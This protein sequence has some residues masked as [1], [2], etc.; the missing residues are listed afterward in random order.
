[1]LSDAALDRVYALKEMRIYVCNL[2]LT[3]IFTVDIDLAAFAQI[4]G[5]AYRPR[6]F[7]AVRFRV[8]Q[9]KCTM[10]VFKSGK[11]VCIGCTKVTHAEAAINQCFRHICKID[12]TAK[13]SKIQVQNIVSHTNLGK[14]VDLLKMSKEHSMKTNY[15][16]ELFPGLRM[17]LR[18]QNARAC[19]FFQG[20]V[21]VTG[22]KDFETLFRVW[23]IV[24]E[25]I[26]P[27][28]ESVASADPNIATNASELNHSSCSIQRHLDRLTYNEDV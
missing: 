13:I 27:Y 14:R 16:P 1:M 4:V 10:L 20:N 28:V 22:C 19:V 11:C 25:R 12:R 8:K 17:S 3:A 2:V 26:Q 23:Q 24:K 15:D 18:E 21:V 7:A 5:G 9:P 6:K